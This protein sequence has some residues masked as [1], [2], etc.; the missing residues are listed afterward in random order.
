HHGTGDLHA[1]LFAVAEGPEHAVGEMV[2]LPLLEHTTCTAFVD[3][4]VGLVPAAGHR[5]RGG[6]DRVEDGLLSRDT[7]CHRGGGEPD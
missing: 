6:H 3:Q 5:V 7:P 4:L 1:L 2:Q